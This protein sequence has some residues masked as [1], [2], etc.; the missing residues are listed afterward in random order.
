MARPSRRRSVVLGAL[1]VGGCIALVTAWRV[2]PR[3]VV[4]IGIERDVGISLPAH[5]P[6]D[7]S[8]DKAVE[9]GFSEP[10]DSQIVLRD[11]I[12]FSMDHA[13]EVPIDLQV[14]VPI[15]TDVLVDQTIHVSLEAPIDMPLTDQELSLGRLTIPV[16]TSILVD[17]EI[18]IDIVVPID[19]SVSSVLGLSVP[20]K[21][22]LP[23]RM[24]VPIKQRV[25]VKDTLD[26]AV[27][28]LHAR[29]HVVVPISA[30]LPLKQAIHVTGQVHVP[31]HRTVPV[32]FDRV[33][34]QPAPEPIPVT[35][36]LPQK[37]PV[38]L[39]ASMVPVVN[40]AGEVPVK[41]GPLRIKPAGVALGVE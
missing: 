19:S 36:T 5:L 24:K 17:D 34:I 6:V 14:D 9:V 29:L 39:S 10:L 20:V 22:N 38:R 8:I 25:H 30:D 33:S 7:V 15:D 1:L 28:D 18:P 31:I 23:V 11:P 13:L 41:V 35:V 40:L 12:R 26:V 4:T 21:A 27:R 32:R 16:D 37:V 2:L 3:V